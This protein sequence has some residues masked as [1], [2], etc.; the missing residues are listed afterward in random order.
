MNL[1][2][3]GGLLRGLAVGSGIVQRVAAAT[4]VLQI[5]SSSGRVQAI[6]VVCHRITGRASLVCY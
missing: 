2:D 5:Y 4:D 6:S 3:M 1:A